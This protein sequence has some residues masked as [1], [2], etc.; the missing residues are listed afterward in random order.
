MDLVAHLI[1]KQL[2]ILT[3]DEKTLIDA[4]HFKFVLYVSFQNKEQAIGL[5]LL[6]KFD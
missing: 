3:S 6:E 4:N 5:E 1:R 2:D